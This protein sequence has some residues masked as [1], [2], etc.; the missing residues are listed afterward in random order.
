MEARR[1]VW[2]TNNQPAEQHTDRRADRKQP[3][4]PS[5][6]LSHFNVHIKKD[7]KFI[8]VPIQSKFRVTLFELRNRK[9]HEQVLGVTP[10]G[11]KG[12]RPPP[13]LSAFYDGGYETK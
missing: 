10:K 1:G 6:L 12:V 8:L 13:P 2:A 3:P 4:S 7:G 11:A 5:P 9:Q